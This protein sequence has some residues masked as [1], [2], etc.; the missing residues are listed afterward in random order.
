MIN[1]GKKS[2]ILEAMEQAGQEIVNNKSVSPEIMA[3]ITQPLTSP[4]MI[5]VLSN[6]T[7]QTMIDGHMTMAEASRQG[8]GIRPDSMGTLMAMLSFAFNPGK[9]GEKSGTLQFNF[10]GDKPG[11]CYFTIDK[12]DI[13]AAEGY[14]KKPTA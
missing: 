13:T 12:G 10:S 2:D 7:W 3:R 11:T 6:L 5:A 8:V 4:E 1:A 9:A 14:R